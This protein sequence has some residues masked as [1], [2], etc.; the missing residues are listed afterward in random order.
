MQ[1]AIAFAILAALAAAAP[2]PVTEVVDAKTGLA[3]RDADPQG[4]A[5]QGGSSTGWNGNP[6]GSSAASGN[7]GSAGW[8]WSYG[9][10]PEAGVAK[11]EADPQGSAAQ[12]GSSTG[13]NGNPNGSSAAS[14]N[15]GSAG[16][17]WSYGS[18]PE[19]GVAKRDADADAGAPVHAPPIHELG[20]K[21]PGAGRSWPAAQGAT[22]QSVDADC[23]PEA[24]TAGQ[25]A[26]TKVSVK[27]G[28]YP[29]VYRRAPDG[30]CQP[31][32]EKA[33]WAPYAR[34]AEAEGNVEAT[35]GK[36]KRQDGGSN[37]DWNGTGSGSGSSGG[38]GSTGFWIP[39]AYEAGISK[40]DGN[41]AAGKR[42]I[43]YSEGGS[44]P[45]KRQDGGSSTGWNG[46]G[47]GSGSSGG[48]G[49]TGF[50]I[51]QAYEAGISKRDA[52]GAR[53]EYPGTEYYAK[54]VHVAGAK[55]RF[56]FGGNDPSGPVLPPGFVTTP[57]KRQGYV[58]GGGPANV[59]NGWHGVSGGASAPLGNQAGAGTW[60]WY[61]SAPYA[62]VARDAEPEAGDKVEARDAEPQGYAYGAGQAGNTNGGWNGAS[63]PLG[64]AAGASIWNYYGSAPYAG[65]AR[66]AENKVDVQARD[67]NADADAGDKVEARDPQP[68][69]YV[70]GGGP[71]NVN[72]G[73]HGVSGGSAPVANAAGGT[74][75]NWYGS[76]PEAGIAKRQAVTGEEPAEVWG[77]VPATPEIVSGGPE[78]V[79]QGQPEVIIGP[80]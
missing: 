18:A 37:T 64:N 42:R 76:A 34:D 20:W 59:N 73:W 12:G 32:V 68:Q 43:M 3:A 22:G 54:G 56:I 10:A 39:Q 55:R 29:P 23:D 79:V 2:L 9:S 70:Y 19:A 21:G 46:T 27:A 28:N 67:A 57:A 52:D 66:D 72:N 17:Y 7:S 36:A 26:G 60:N 25:L 80:A 45:A 49:S 5:A 11:R 8:Y 41:E 50:W 1:L 6:N 31:V 77:G 75:W 24:D 61:S 40:R 44:A 13:W 30:T 4:S 58:Y 74:V 33:N 62:G 51:P 65:V 16:W 47:S 15:S 48:A 53:T 71:A 63:A 35:D 14:G 69:G 78:V 38:A